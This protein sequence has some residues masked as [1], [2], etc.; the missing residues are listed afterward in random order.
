M[1]IHAWTA[2]IKLLGGV[3]EISEC[4]NSN[5]GVHLDIVAWKV[6]FWFDFSRSIALFCVQKGKG[7]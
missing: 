2:P 5:K 1:Q 3:L 6:G 7:A 4:Q